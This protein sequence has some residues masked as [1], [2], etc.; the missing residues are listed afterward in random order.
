MNFKVLIGFLT[1]SVSLVL[2]S[3]LVVHGVMKMPSEVEVQAEQKDSSSLSCLHREPLVEAFGRLART[4]TE[5]GDRDMGRLFELVGDTLLQCR[6][7]EIARVV[8]MHFDLTRGVPDGTPPSM[9]DIPAIEQEDMSE[10]DILKYSVP[11]AYCLIQPN[12]TL[13]CGD[14]PSV[15]TY[16]I[17]KNYLERQ[18]T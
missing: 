6:E 17:P 5:A 11:S 7:A 10:E 18:A 2:V 15:E 12:G 16:P 14:E 1:Y 9:L 4:S 3:F 13:L 8:A